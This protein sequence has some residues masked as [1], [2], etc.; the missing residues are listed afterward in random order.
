MDSTPFFEFKLR[1]IKSGELAELKK[2]H[3]SYFD[4]DHIINTA[5]ELKY[6]NEFKALLLK[7]ISDPSEDFITLF[8][9]QVFPKVITAKVKE[10]FAPIIKRSFNQLIS[11]AINERL[12]SALNQEKEKNAAEAMKI[13]ETIVAS[14]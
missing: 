14:K 6:L 7:E 11:D 12:K 1:E 4:V 2:F 5:S 9:K 13:A 3:K 10:Q 8:T